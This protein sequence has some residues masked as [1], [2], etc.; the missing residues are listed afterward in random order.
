M[1][2]LTG[3]AGED[4]ASILRALGYRMERRPPP[5]PKPAVVEAPLAE[6]APADAAPE[7]T[8]AA[9]EA[10]SEAAPVEGA[11]A[12]AVA[13]ETPV[14]LEAS[15]VADGSN[16]VAL[17]SCSAVSRVAAR[18]RHTSEVAF[19]QVTADEPVAVEASS[20]EVFSFEVLPEPVAEAEPQAVEAPQDQA[21]TEA[22]AAGERLP[23]AMLQR[24]IRSP[25]RRRPMPWRGAGNGRGL[26][27]RWPVGR[28]PA[29]S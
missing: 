10:S 3:S 4:F 11:I 28:A 26:A 24:R 22:T 25:L 19:S 2:S 27:A 6:A 29:A 13:A 18:M 1:T 14:A 20:A 7:V 17:R 23:S 8:A 12:E 16:D 21:V 9:A 5:P 15:S